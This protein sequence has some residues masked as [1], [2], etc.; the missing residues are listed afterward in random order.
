[1]VS[2][3]ASQRRNTHPSKPTTH[4]LKEPAAMTPGA[5]RWPRPVERAA[6]LRSSQRKHKEKVKHRI[7][8]LESRL[9]TTECKLERALAAISTL[10]DELRAVLDQTQRPQP[11][12]QSQRSRSEPLTSNP[13][14]SRAAQISEATS[15]KQREHVRK[16]T[17]PWENDANPEDFSWSSAFL[18]G[19]NRNGGRARPAA[20]AGYHRSDNG[21]G[22]GTGT[23][24]VPS[25][26]V[27]EVSNDM[28]ADASTTSRQSSD[29]PASTQSPAELAHE[30]YDFVDIAAMK[31]WIDPRFE[32]TFRRA[33]VDRIQHS[34]LFALMDFISS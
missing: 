18:E 27:S 8:D 15:P 12:P 29:T 17:L 33:D 7:I 25:S 16:L 34:S 23:G 31:D 13:S 9:F 4:V 21:D 24:N 26:T 3:P 22:N 5:H 30:S 1:M 20:T 32:K 6:R 19:V 14:S 2:R 11:Q 10:S 28:D